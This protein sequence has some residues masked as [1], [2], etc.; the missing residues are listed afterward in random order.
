MPL[1]FL[2]GRLVTVAV[3]PDENRMRW[4]LHEKL[5][6]LNSLFFEDVFNGPEPKDSIIFPDEDP[7][8]FAKI[9]RWAYGIAF[10]TNN[11]GPPRLFRYQIPDEDEVPVRDYLSV[12]VL[13]G[14]FQMT[15]C[16]NAA[17]DAVYAYFKADLGRRPKMSD[18]TYIFEHTEPGSQMRRLMILVSVQY[19]FSERRVK[20][21]GVMGLPQ[22]SD[23]KE[24]LMASPEMGKLLPFC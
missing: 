3:G 5:L 6:T 10:T 16:R 17:I 19:L 11:G 21:D 7:K 12:Y 22:D 23:W 20:V 13:A 8:I 2:A 18:L 9:V 4:Q 14:K 1:S 24:A 15:A